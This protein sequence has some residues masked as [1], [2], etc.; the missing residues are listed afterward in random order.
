MT[1][2]NL[3]SIPIHGFDPKSLLLVINSTIISCF[4]S[5]YFARYFPLGGSIK[6][7]KYARCVIFVLVQPLY[8]LFSA[9]LTLIILLTARVPQYFSKDKPYY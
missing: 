8:Y 4:I 6:Y 2:I 9:W 7:Q 5:I 1:N 3:F